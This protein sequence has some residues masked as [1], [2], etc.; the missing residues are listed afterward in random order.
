MPQNYVTFEPVVGG[1]PI[2]RL[3]SHADNKEH[4][5][6]G[7][8]YGSNALTF[9]F[10]GTSNSLPEREKNRLMREALEKVYN[11]FTGRVAEA[12][13]DDSKL[14]NAIL[15]HYRGSQNAPDAKIVLHIVTIDPNNKSDSYINAL[16]KMEGF[17]DVSKTE[18]VTDVF[19]H[20]T[21]LTEADRSAAERICDALV[22]MRAR[23]AFS[24]GSLNDAQKKWLGDLWNDRSGIR[25][26][27]DAAQN[28]YSTR[29]ASL[30]RPDVRE[31]FEKAEKIRAA[32]NAQ[33]RYNGSQPVAGIPTTGTAQVG[34]L[35]AA[36]YPAPQ[37]GPE[38]RREPDRTARTTGSAARQELISR[39]GVPTSL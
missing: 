39:G 8:G 1:P 9:T 35:G 2:H 28:R 12:V 14:G 16:N 10:E 19:H 13:D 27:L 11:N 33:P 20:L 36:G 38:Q 37:N 7:A 32:E 30:Q 23:G 26:A 34:V 15:A 21:T 6:A 29:Q 31:A 17:I 4:P 3:G 24:Y 18:L 25:D 5:A 22:D